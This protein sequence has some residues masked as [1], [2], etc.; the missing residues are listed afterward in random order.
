MI[1]YGDV[2]RV[3]MWCRRLVGLWSIALRKR[4]GRKLENAWE[5]RSL[6]RLVRRQA[7]IQRK[8]NLQVL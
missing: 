6:N 1:L 7:G 4:R 3:I 5:R 8:M 2:V